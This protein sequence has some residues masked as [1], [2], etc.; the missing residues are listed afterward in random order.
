[1]TFVF[2]CT[3]DRMFFNPKQNRYPER[4]G[5]QICRITNGLGREVEGPR[6]SKSADALRSFPTTNFNRN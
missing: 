1:V 2:S 6:R 5:A 3:P 4:S